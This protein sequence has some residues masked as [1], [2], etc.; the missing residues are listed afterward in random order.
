MNPLLMAALRD[1]ENEPV[2]AQAPPNLTV[3][4]RRSITTVAQRG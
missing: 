3:L 1:G 2:V 4:H